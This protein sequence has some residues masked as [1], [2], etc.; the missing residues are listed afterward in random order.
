MPALTAYC[1]ERLGFIAY[2]ESRQPEQALIYLNKAIDIYPTSEPR[3]WLVQV[4]LLRSRVLRESNLDAAIESARMAYDL[5]YSQNKTLSAESLFTLS[6]LLSVNNGR[7]IEVVDFIQ[8]FIQVSKA[9]VGVDVTWSRAYEMLGDSYFAMRQYAEAITSY[10]NA[11]QYNPDHPWE[12]TIYYRIAKA[13]YQQQQYNEVV[14]NLQ[15]I[16]G[17]SQDYRV[18]N[19]LANAYYGLR[20][21]KQAMYSYQTAINLAPS[22]IN[23]ETM[24]MYYQLSQQMNPPL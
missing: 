9:P 23:I 21:F 12:E 20:Q 22:G 6:E 5:A 7:E 1:Y 24:Q 19:L 16:I 3:L 13:H 10:Q 18:F 11:L 15:V 2:Y 14:D 17:D 4:Y 8:Q